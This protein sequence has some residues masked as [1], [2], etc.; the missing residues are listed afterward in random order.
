MNDEQQRICDY[1]N[2][3]A[4]G[5]DNRNLLLKLEIHCI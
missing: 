1:L 4:I 5:Y 3:N 2:Q